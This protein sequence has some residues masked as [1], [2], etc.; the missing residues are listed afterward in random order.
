MSDEFV[1]HLIR[2]IND[3]CFKNSSS[4][5]VNNFSLFLAPKIAKPMKS[6]SLTYRE[7]KKTAEKRKDFFVANDLNSSVFCKGLYKNLMY[8]LSF[9]SADNFYDDIVNF[10]RVVENGNYR[11]FPKG[12]SEDTLRSTL[13]VYIREETFCEPRSSS[14]F[15]DITIPSQKTIIETKLWKGKEYYNAGLPELNDYL[16][17][18]NYQEGYYVI[19]DYSQ[20]SNEIIKSSG[21]VFDITYDGKMIHV[22]FVLMN[23]VSPS[24]IYTSK[25]QKD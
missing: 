11:G 24:K 12:T 16:N 1:K 17:K 23:R 7:F 10:K 25:K 21:E 20:S 2:I 5:F 3:Y 6:G 14:G 19:F 9:I 18:A 22:V 13:S 15:N 4:Q 8:E